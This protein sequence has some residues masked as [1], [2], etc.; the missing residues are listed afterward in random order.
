LVTLE[1]NVSNCWANVEGQY[2]RR[3]DLIPNMVA[4]VKVM[5]NT[6]AKRWKA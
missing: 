3:A 5:P 2:Q 6:K 4:T 1:E